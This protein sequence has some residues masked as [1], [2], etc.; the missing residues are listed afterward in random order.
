MNTNADHFPVSIPMHDTEFIDSIVVRTEPRD[1]FARYFIA[2]DADLAA[3][4][5]YVRARPF[6]ELR[7]LHDLHA[8]SRNPMLALFDPHFAPVPEYDAVCLVAY[9]HDHQPAATIAARIV[10]VATSN[11]KAAMEDLTFWFGNKAPEFQ[12]SSVCHVGIPHAANLKGRILYAG[13]MWTRPDLRYAELAIVLTRLLRIYSYCQ[14]D[15]DF[16]VAVAQAK[17][18]RKDVCSRY[19][20]AHCDLGFWWDTNGVRNIEG[21]LL[22]SP[23]SHMAVLAAESLRDY[24]LKSPLVLNRRREQTVH[25]VPFQQ[26]QGQT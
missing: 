25:P 12:D 24:D 17:F 8:A 26:G 1:L 4:G 9:D 7:R 11:V 18:A 15:F 14:L 3:R 10:N 22:W 5:M 20:F 13:A 23:G 19:A 6:T 16:E 2:V 21:P